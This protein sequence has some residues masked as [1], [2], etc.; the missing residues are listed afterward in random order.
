MSYSCTQDLSNDA[1][2]RLVEPLLDEVTALREPFSELEAENAAFREE[3]AGFKGL[4]GRPKLK[5]SGMEKATSGAKAKSKCK[6]MKRAKRRSPVLNEERKL[7]V[8]AP[9]GSQFK[10][11]GDFVVQD[12]RIEGAGDSL[13]TGTLSDTRGQADCGAFAGRFARPF[14]S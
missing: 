10:G 8:G 14:R 5:P 4:K 9:A 12:L 7:S 6:K 13:S 2:R 11:Y 3:N 1:L